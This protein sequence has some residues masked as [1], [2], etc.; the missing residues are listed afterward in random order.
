MR[1]IFICICKKCKV[2]AR[3]ANYLQE[4]QSIC[5]KCK[6]F[7]RNAKNLQRTS[8]GVKAHLGGLGGSEQSQLTF[9]LPLVVRW[10]GMGEKIGMIKNSLQ[11]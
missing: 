6:E 10:V 8:S 5:K 11:L 2:F 3:N 1:R 4:M 9:I 7:A